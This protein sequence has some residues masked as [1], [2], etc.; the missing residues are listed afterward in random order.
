[1]LLQGHT[2]TQ[3]AKAV[4]CHRTYV[5]KLVRRHGLPTNKPIWPGSRRAQEAQRLRT[6]F[7]TYAQIAAVM[8][9]TPTKV[10]EALRASAA[11]KFKALG[12]EAVEEQ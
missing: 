4:G 2:V 6:M 5:Y 8:G 3:T 9:T 12:A 1:M 11:L 10:E 7:F